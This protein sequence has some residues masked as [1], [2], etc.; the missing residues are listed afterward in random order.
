MIGWSVFELYDICVLKSKLRNKKRF[1]D[2]HAMISHD[3]WIFWGFLA[4]FAPFAVQV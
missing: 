3:F 1:S 4:E 2:R